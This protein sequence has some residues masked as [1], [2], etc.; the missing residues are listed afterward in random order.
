M[1]T[2]HDAFH[3]YPTPTCMLSMMQGFT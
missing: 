3:T 1:I 2:R